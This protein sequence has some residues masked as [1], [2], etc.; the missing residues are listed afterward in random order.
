MKEE[1]LDSQEMK[2]SNIFVF[3]RRKVNAKETDMREDQ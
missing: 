3:S 1:K 2:T